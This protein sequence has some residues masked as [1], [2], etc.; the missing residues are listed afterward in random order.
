MIIIVMSTWKLLKDSLTL[1]L[2]A[3]PTDINLE[4]IK[5]AAL[6]LPGIKDIH[7]IHV[8]ALSTSDNA[9][10]AHIVVDDSSSH[11]DISRI[12]ENL[13]H[14]LQHLGVQHATIETETV[15]CE[16]ETCREY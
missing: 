11:E 9:M 5:S 15:A 3:V 14:E 1:S 6:K 4:K 7:H 12:K 13:K 2:D 8:W 10:T 16:D